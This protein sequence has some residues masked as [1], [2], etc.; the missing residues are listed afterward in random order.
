MLTH[1]APRRTTSRIRVE[2]WTSTHKVTRG[3][4]WCLGEIG[5]NIWTSGMT[6]ANWCTQAMTRR[7]GNLSKTSALGFELTS[8]IED[9]RYYPDSD[10]FSLGCLIG[11]MSFECHNQTIQAGTF[12]FLLS[13]LPCLCISGSIIEFWRH[14]PIS[15]TTDTF[16]AIVWGNTSSLMFLTAIP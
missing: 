8:C 16:L 1:L 2:K 12:S 6:M 5:Q 10:N 3:T 11:K 9:R 15:T 7:F 14:K 13:E 4:S